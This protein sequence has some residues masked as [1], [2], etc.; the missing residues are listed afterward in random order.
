MEI[1]M[2]FKETRNMMEKQAE[3]NNKTIEAEWQQQGLQ[4]SALLSHKH[5]VLICNKIR[6]YFPIVI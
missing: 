6:S 2:S 5:N 3:E 4:P 1:Y